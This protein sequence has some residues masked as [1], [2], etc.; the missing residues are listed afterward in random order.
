MRS[1]GSDNHSGIHPNILKAISEANNH[2]DEAYGYDTLTKKLETRLSEIFGCHS[3]YI[4]FNGTGANVFALKNMTDSYSSIIAAETAHINVDECGAPEKHTGCKI[5]VVATP[6]GKLT[7]ELAKAKIVGLGSEH[8]SQPKVISIS[9]PTE[10]GTVYSPEEIKALSDL[11]HENGMYLHVDGAR[12]ANAISS[13]NCDPKDIT[14]N[15]GV[16]AIS[17]GGTKN[18]LMIGEAVMFFNPELGGRAI[19]ERKHLTQLYS[20]QRFIAAQLLEYLKDDLWLNLAKHSN[21]MAKL[22]ASKVSDIDCIQITQSVDTNAV[23]AIVPK[24]LSEHLMEHYVFYVWDEFT[25]EVRWMTSFDTT[26]DDINSFSEVVARF[27]CKV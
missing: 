3:S 26:E 24:D 4:V 9:Q 5:S 20:K 19:F 7:P 16:D 14:V 18:G 8:H 2:H 17:L 6:D 23:F 13:L 22:L 21:S 11:A 15:A 27:S 1:F 10:L 12:L 25:N